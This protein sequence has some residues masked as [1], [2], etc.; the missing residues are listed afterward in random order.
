MKF[1]SLRSLTEKEQ[2]ATD[3]QRAATDLAKA[4]TMQLYIVNGVLDP[5]EVRK[6]LADDGSF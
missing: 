2:A 4:Q 5:S 3:Q 1:A 6:K